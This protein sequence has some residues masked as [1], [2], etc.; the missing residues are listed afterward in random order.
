MSVFYLKWVQAERFS[1]ATEEA[2]GQARILTSLDLTFSYY[3]PV[4]RAS[5][6]NQA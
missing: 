2:L 6:T 1:Q 3:L 4:S 5:Q